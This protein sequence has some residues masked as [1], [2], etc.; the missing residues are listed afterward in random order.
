MKDRD[1]V[2]L[3]VF[4]VHWLTNYAV[5]DND[6]ELMCSR[7]LLPPFV[8][9]LL[10]VCTQHVHSSGDGFLWRLPVIAL[11]CENETREWR[12]FD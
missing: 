1:G 4:F 11:C 8:S 6:V 2:K 7:N 3:F 5:S 9:S 10:T 12:G